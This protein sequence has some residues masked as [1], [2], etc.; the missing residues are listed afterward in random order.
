MKKNSEVDAT[1]FREFRNPVPSAKNVKCVQVPGDWLAPDVKSGDWVFIDP[2][3][4]TP[5][6]GSVALFQALDGEL[7]IHRFRPLLNDDFEA[8]DANGRTMSHSRH[9]IK[10][11]GTVL[12]LQ[13][14]VL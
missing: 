5:K 12:T 4:T 6:L 11:L 8:Y 7:F 3:N 10:I 13:R 14:D 9:G 1:D 2:H